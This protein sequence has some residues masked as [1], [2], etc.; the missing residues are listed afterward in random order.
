[1]DNKTIT[2]DDAIFFMDM[3]NS[4]KSPNDIRGFYKR[5][6]YYKILDEKDSDEYQRFMRIYN[7]EKHILKE[8]ERQI[9]DDLYGL[10][11]PRMTLKE[12]GIPHNITQE[13]VRQLRHRAEITIV[14]NLVKQ[15]KG[16][17]K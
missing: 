9:L 6:S 1:M 7:A 14:R 16:I 13:R 10:T 12:A 8:R 11:K 4:A 15:F 2:S 17:A 5:K 3:V